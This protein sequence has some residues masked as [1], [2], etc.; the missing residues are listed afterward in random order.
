MECPIAF[1]LV[2]Y[3]VFT[4]SSSNSAPLICNPFPN[5]SLWSSQIFLLFNFSS[6]PKF[7]PRSLPRYA[8]GFSLWFVPLPS[9]ECLL[10]DSIFPAQSPDATKVASGRRME[11][12][13]AHLELGVSSGVAAVLGGGFLP[14]RYRTLI[15]QSLNIP[16]VIREIRWKHLFWHSTFSFS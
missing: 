2:S 3:S 11:K 12:D 13:H 4:D 16:S 10:Q 14:H 7:I 6:L 9:S 15:A 5:H 8:R 1:S